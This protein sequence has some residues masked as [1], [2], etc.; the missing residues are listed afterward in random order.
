MESLDEWRP[1]LRAGIEMKCRKDKRLLKDGVSS[2]ECLRVE[3]LPGQV[4]RA[5]TE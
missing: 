1:A 3:Y 2:L 5:G 4:C